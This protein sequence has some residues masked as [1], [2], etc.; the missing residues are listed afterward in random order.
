MPS[1]DTLAVHGGAPTIPSGPPGWPPA[2][3]DVR[4]ALERCL[5]DGDWGR[6]EGKYTAE[7][8]K[9]LRETFRV[10]YVELCASGTAAVEL[11]LRGLKIGPGDATIV[12]GYD[13]KGNAANVLTVGAALVLADVELPSA[14]LAPAAFAE[15]VGS[16][17]KA[18]VVSHLHGGCAKMPALL[19]IAKSA[20]VAVVDD[21]CQMPGASLDGRPLGTWGDVGVLSFGGSKLLTAGRGGAVLTSDARIAQRIRL[22]TERGNA[23]Y[24]LS[25]LQAAVLLPQ[26]ASLAADRAR[27]RHGARYFQTRLAEIPGLAPLAAPPNADP[28]FY[29]F[30]LVYN[31]AAW[32]RAP[33]D[34]VAA[35]LR[36]EGVACDPGFQALARSFA[37][38]RFR[39]VGHLPNA[40][41]LGECLLIL[42]HPV[43]S[44]PEA[45]RAAVVA[46]FR[47]VHRAA[48]DGAFDG[49]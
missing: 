16:A 31:P 23:A 42:H 21:A 39:S 2:R 28:D 5:R 10:E 37:A 41:T 46:A 45:A 4:E 26:L 35:A 29:K 15:A 17:A 43:L 30:G 13:F 25:E 33:R 3:D 12:A 34:A 8:R 14:T 19:E 40:L 1:E 6:Y 9:R 18:V 20:G 32:N 49:E 47:K 22:Y 48:L 44:E 27:R 7:L 24:P 11:A 36:A 38:T